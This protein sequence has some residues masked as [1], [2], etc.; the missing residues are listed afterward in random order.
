MLWLSR[1]CKAAPLPVQRSGV[2]DDHPVGK[3]GCL[4]PP[5]DEGLIGGGLFMD[6]VFLILPKLAEWLQI[7]L[8]SASPPRRDSTPSHT[9]PK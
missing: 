6:G 1:A 8:P 9:H 7:L 4:H 5:W 2:S 3:A